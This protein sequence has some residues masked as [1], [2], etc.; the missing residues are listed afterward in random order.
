MEQG[1]STNTLEKI[2]KTTGGTN[3]NKCIKKA[4]KRKKNDSKSDLKQYLTFSG[5]KQNESNVNINITKTNYSTNNVQKSNSNRMNSESSVNSGSD[6]S[7][8]N[9]VVIAEALKVL[10]YPKSSIDHQKIS[11]DKLN[12]A[13]GKL[14]ILL[15]SAELKK[16]EFVINLLIK[17]I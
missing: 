16:S 10:K 2:L 7:T 17:G 12:L 4:D 9:K 1:S 6:L 11:L 14:F 5:Y 15:I 8:T 13:K 3:S